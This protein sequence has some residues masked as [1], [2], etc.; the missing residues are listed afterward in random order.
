MSSKIIMTES[1]KETVNTELGINVDG[2]S[3]EELLQKLRASK[4]FV[5][6]LKE[7]VTYKVK[8]VLNG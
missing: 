4:K 8:Q 3:D 7:N 5:V 1:T 6:I 2:L